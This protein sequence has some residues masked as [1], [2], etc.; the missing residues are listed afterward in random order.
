MTERT[1]NYILRNAK[2]RLISGNVCEHSLQ[3]IFLLV[4]HSRPSEVNKKNIIYPMFYIIVKLGLPPYGR[5][6]ESCK[7]CD[8]IKPFLSTLGPPG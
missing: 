8:L 5:V 1:Q 7:T 3:I 6:S 4:S 2:S